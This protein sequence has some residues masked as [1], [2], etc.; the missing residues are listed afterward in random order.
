MS[1]FVF[2][3][4]S[5]LEF[6][7]HRRDLCRQLL[8]QVLAAEANLLAER[9]SALASR[10]R[11]FEEI[12][13][14]SRQGRVVVEAAISRRYHSG[15]ILLQ[16]RII[17]EKRRLVSQQLQLCRDALVKADTEVKVLERLEERQ[18]Q[19]FA[20]HAERHIQFEREDAWMAR[21]L[22]EAVR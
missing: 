19:E 2:R 13:G 11:Q 9:Q 6:R 7:R 5:L 15:Q 16:V 17:E 8:A 14:L 3:L 4:R 18:R 21:R 20:Y 1:G 12:R 10:A 22:Q